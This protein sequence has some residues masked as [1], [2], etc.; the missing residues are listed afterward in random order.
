MECCVKEIIRQASY[1]HLESCLFPRYDCKARLR[2]G[3]LI[4]AEPMKREIDPVINVVCPIQ[5][6]LHLAVDVHFETCLRIH[7]ESQQIH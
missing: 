1:A 3:T 2:D 5:E 6:P 7:T 4:L